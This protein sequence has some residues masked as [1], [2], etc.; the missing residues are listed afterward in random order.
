MVDNFSLTEVTMKAN[1]HLF[2]LVG[3]RVECDSIKFFLKHLSKIQWDDI[4]EKYRP[5]LE[6]MAVNEDPHEIYMLQSN[7]IDSYPKVLEYIENLNGDYEFRDN[8]RVICD[9]DPFETIM[10]SYFLSQGCCGYYDKVVD[11]DGKT[12]KIGFNYG[13]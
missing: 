5:R 4:P 1:K 3:G 13:H 2:N 10:Y 6:N 8:F 12:Y 7:I 9:G 11:I